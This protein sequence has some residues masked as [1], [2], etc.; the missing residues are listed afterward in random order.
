ISIDTRTLKSGDLFVALRGP[1]FDGHQFVAAAQ[2]AGAA[3]FLVADD[4]AN[5]S[6]SLDDKLVRVK[7]TFTA[8][9]DLG[10]AARSRTAA[11][12]V[13]VTGSV[14]KTGTKDMLRTALSALG[15]TH[16]SSGNLNNHWG[17]PLSLA[18]MPR[19][20]EF[21]VFELGMNHPDEIAPLSRLVRPHAAIVTAVTAAHLEFFK[22]IDDIAAEK[23]SIAAGLERGGTFVLPADSPHVTVLRETARKFGAAKILTFG[24]QGNADARLISV[25]TEATGMQIAAEIAGTRLTYDIGLTGRHL[26]M[27]SLAVL[28]AVS[29]LGVNVRAAAANLSLVQPTEG[30][31][32]RH[33]VP[34]SNGFVTV[35]DESYN[36]SPA[37]VLALVESLGQSRAQSGRVIVALGDMLEL[38]PDSPAHHA[39]LASP[40]IANRVD[41]VFTCGTLMEHLHNALPRELRGG[42]AK[43]SAALA[44]LIAQAV[45]AGDVVAVKGSHGSAMK[46]IV[47]A[48]LALGARASAPRAVNGE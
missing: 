38:G 17:V 43:D 18:R 36:A 11:G 32:A 42:H 19:D 27:N 10:R 33:V 8:L 7:D 2:A 30:R 23:A 16:A 47:D 14:G 20:A 24:T 4:A 6:S 9:N 22:S 25:A 15:A 29:A 44:P 12:I 48:L 40:L 39:G 37:A 31:G 3:G 28:A 26:A 1:R 13:A 45:Q 41:L 34:V 46:K 5:I 21:G 35:I